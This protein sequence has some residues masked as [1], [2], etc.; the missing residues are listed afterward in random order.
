MEVSNRFHNRVSI[1]MTVTIPDPFLAETIAA[2]NLDFVMID[3]EH[4]AMSSYQLQNYLIGLRTTNAATLVRVPHNDP[5]PVMQAIDLGA[6]GVVV[7]HIESREEIA[8]AIDAAYYPPIGNRGVG[9]RRAG[10]LPHSESYLSRA[11]SEISVVGMIESQMAVNNLQDI[12]QCPCLGGVIIGKADLAASLGHLV[13][14]DHPD[15]MQAIDSIF[16]ACVSARVPFGMYSANAE[17]GAELARR[18]AGIITIGSDLL[19]MERA[20]DQSLSSYSE[21]RDRASD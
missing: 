14:P 11:N 6:D 5:I 19:F 16:D 15:V 13:E 7:P 18:G 4:S 9:A 17:Q 3:N 21:V 2:R 12:L 1:G 20:L 8:K 10:R